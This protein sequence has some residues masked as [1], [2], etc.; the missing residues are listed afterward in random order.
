MKEQRH[1]GQTAQI[2]GEKT[3]RLAKGS[4]GACTVRDGFGPDPDRPGQGTDLP[5]GATGGPEGQAQGMGTMG[6]HA[7]PF[8]IPLRKTADKCPHT[9]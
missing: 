5:S 9:K 4:R 1:W 6:E 3:S 2:L 8:R 7:F